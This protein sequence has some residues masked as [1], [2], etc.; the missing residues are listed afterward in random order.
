MT[1]SPDEYTVDFSIPGEADFGMSDIE[2]TEEVLETLSEEATQCE[3]ST[4][5]D[6]YEEGEEPINLIPVDEQRLEYISIE[7]QLKE[8]L[9]D[10][11]DHI[12]E[13]GFKKAK[14]NDSTSLPIEE[15]GPG[16]F[17]KEVKT[18]R[19]RTAYIYITKNAIG[20]DVGQEYAI[21]Y[22]PYVFKYR[23]KKEFALAFNKVFSEVLSS[24]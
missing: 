13:L 4:E 9:G 6:E 15:Y 8:S 5:I 16:A 3:L 17:I 23:S 21:T 18:L 1:I 14:Y 22:L 12:K 10:Y 11:F 19:L 7:D 24:H 2:V 20:V